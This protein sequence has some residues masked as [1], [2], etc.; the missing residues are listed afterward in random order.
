M[1]L[2]IP[3]AAFSALRRMRSSSASDLRHL[4]AKNEGLRRYFFC[5]LVTKD[6]TFSKGPA[7]YRRKHVLIVYPGFLGPRCLL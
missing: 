6:P 4:L 3:E 2:R 5:T 1:H 7:T